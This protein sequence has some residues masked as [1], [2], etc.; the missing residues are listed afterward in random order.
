LGDRG[1]PILSTFYRE[2]SYIVA[3][4]IEVTRAKGWRKLVR[5]GG[6]ADI[7]SRGRKERL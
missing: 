2:S 6:G 3:G 7:K 4:R 1:E 5:T